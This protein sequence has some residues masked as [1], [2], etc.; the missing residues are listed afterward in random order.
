MRT[1]GII[2][3]IAPEST[4]DYYR[5]IVAA[6]RAARP[7]GSY[8]KIFINSIDM[9]RLL[10]LAGADNLSTL[11]EYLSEQVAVLAR[12]GAEVALFASNTPHLVFDAVQKRSDIPLVSIVEA[13]CT[14]AKSRGL[15]RVGLM[16]TKFT[17]QSRFYA[18][19]FGTQGLAVV[20]P[21]PDEQEFVHSR[22]IGELV[23]GVFQPETRNRILS[24]IANMSK[25]ERLDAMVLAGTELPLLLRTESAEG[26]PLLDTTGIH[27]SAALTHLLA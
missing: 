25:R 5:R 8:P 4:I 26:L 10:A 1:L 15:R 11:V 20:S 7:D 9:G 16:G 19:V 12:A 27:V 14:V 24:I 17:M 18:D 6:Y 2:G 22:Y 13:T 23:E 21:Q 3:G